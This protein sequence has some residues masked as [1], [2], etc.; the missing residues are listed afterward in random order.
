MT[1]QAHKVPF[2][3]PEEQASADL[4]GTL[5]DQVAAANRRL[6]ELEADNEEL[7][8]QLDLADLTIARYGEGEL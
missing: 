3:R 6:R 2:L 8:Q 4:V 1:L 5:I 7:R